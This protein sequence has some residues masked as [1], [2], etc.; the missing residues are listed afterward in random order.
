MFTSNWACSYCAQMNFQGQQQT[1]IA[2]I[3][4]AYATASYHRK[5]PGWH[6]AFNLR[7]LWSCA[8]VSL[9]IGGRWRSLFW[10]LA[11]NWRAWTSSIG[12][13]ASN[14]RTTDSRCVN[15]LLVTRTRTHSLLHTVSR[16]PRRRRKAEVPC[17]VLCYGM[18]V[19]SC[20]L[21]ICITVSLHIFS[22]PFCHS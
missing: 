20:V 6:S 7:M 2:R 21:P 19:E 4:V 1:F 8:G 12:H 16:R 14:W 22:A 18:D 13:S 5:D 9:S 11:L 15:L 3:R 17:N 10:C